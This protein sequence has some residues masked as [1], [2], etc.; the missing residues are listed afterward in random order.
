M[1]IGNGFKRIQK[2]PTIL[3]MEAVEC[4]AVALAIV[5]AYYDRWI[6]LDVLRMDCGVSRDGSRADNIYRAAV[7]HGLD[8]EAYSLEPADIFECRLP[9]IIHWEFNHFVVL[10]GA[11]KHHVYINDPAY[12]RRKLSLQAFDEGFTGVLLELTPTP[13]FVRA[14]HKPKI[15]TS[16]MARLRHSK[17]AVG[18]II[19]ATLSLAIPGIAIAGLNKI[20]IDEVLIQQLNHWQRPV[21]LG[22]LIAGAFSALL[23]WYQ[24]TML[25]RLEVKMALV[26]GA[27]F[28]WHL[29]RLPMSFFN[30]RYLGDILNRLQSSDSVASLV[31]QQFGTNLV[32][33]LL[34]LIYLVILFL[35]SVP[36]TLLVL[37]A[38]AINIVA[39]LVI[40]Q[41]RSSESQ[42]QTKAQNK[43]MSTAISGL[44][45]IETYKASGAEQ[46][47]FKKFAGMHANYLTAEQQLSWTRDCFAALPLALDL[48][49]NAGILCF[50]AWLAIE[51]QLSIGTVVA[52]QILYRSFI[53]PVKMLVMLAGTI[54]DIAADLFHLEDITSHPVARRYEPVSEKSAAPHAKLNGHVVFEQVTFGYSPLADPLLRDFSIDIQPGRRLALV[55]SSGS[56]KSTIGKL[57]MGFYEP[58]SGRILIDG[59]ELHQI[60]NAVRVRSIASVDQDIS[61]FHATLKDNLTLWDPTVDDEA[62]LNACKAVFMHDMIAGEREMGY[63][64]MINEGGSNFSGG[65]RQR[66]EIARA[67]LQK[68]S[69]LILDE[70]TSALDA[71]MEK[72]IDTALRRLGCTL[73]IISHRLSTIR[74]ADEII[75][76]EQGQVIER[77]SHDQLLA[78]NGAYCRLLASEA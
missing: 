29:I 19:L 18:F 32:S 50:G 70:A 34:A 22:L 11:S 49:T 2:T 37:L 77:G 4:G 72:A 17:E 63:E 61:L 21:L 25:S 27:S 16:L 41:K 67:M 24:R 53:Q 66:L 10:E 33:L 6:P 48:L 30:Q 36:L 47:F 31:S 51:G 65:Q 73:L 59:K 5:L 75:V 12:G 23:T 76:L 69:I 56:G 28:F 55:G 44:Q 8:V 74:D 43:L 68:P 54:Q 3:Q 20:F 64:S 9:A 1:N 40:A 13:Q 45:M 58:W 46:D 15:F 71:Q 35:L 52:F 14:G 57:L 39:L 38:T 26:N 42:R 78:L 60:P 62:I 7:L